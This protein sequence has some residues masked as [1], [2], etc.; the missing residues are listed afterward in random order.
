MCV[1]DCLRTSEHV[2][3]ASNLH[4]VSFFTSSPKTIGDFALSTDAPLLPPV[5]EEY[6]LPQIIDSPR[7]MIRPA[8]RHK[9]QIFFQNT[10]VHAPTSLTPNLCCDPEKLFGP[11]CTRDRDTLGNFFGCKTN[12]AQNAS[13]TTIHEFVPCGVVF[14]ELRRQR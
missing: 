9:N 1:R 14:W 2:T 13:R 11:L 7:E 3:R 12:F 6:T 4:N 8:S 5:T 10:R